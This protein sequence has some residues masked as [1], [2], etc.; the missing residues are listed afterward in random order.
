M[1]S[2]S[3]VDEP[4]VRALA[5]DRGAGEN[6]TEALWV[7]TQRE[8]LRL[9]AASLQRQASLAVRK[10]RH[11]AADGA[12]GLWAAGRERL[13]YFGEGEGLLIDLSRPLES[14][15]IVDLTV[16]PADQS[17][18]LAGRDEL[19][20]VLPD[21]RIANR[22]NLPHK[23]PPGHIAALGL[24]A[25]VR[26]PELA[27][28]AP[29]DGALLADASPA[30][31]LSHSDEGSGVD[32]ATLTIR[33]GGEPLAIVCQSTD[34]TN[35]HSDCSVF[36]VLDQGAN[37]LSA[38]IA[39]YAGN[40]SEPVE[41][42][43]TIDTIPPTITL[44][45]PLDG[46]WTNADEVIVA[47][48]LSENAS[49]RLNGE[50]VSLGAD[51]QF[52]HAV[53]LAEDGP[54][55][56][57]LAAEDA[58]G[59]RTER[60]V[61]VH[62]DTVAPGAVDVEGVAIEA[63][64]VE[65]TVRIHGAQGTVE[66]GTEVVI[67]NTRTGET[68]V[69][70][71]D[72]S[73]AFAASVVGRPS[74]N[75]E[76]TVRDRAG[77]ES[78][79]SEVTGVIVPPDPPE[80]APPLPQTG[81]APM[82][83]QV[84]FLYNGSSPI[85]RE[86]ASGTIEQR[87]VSVLKGSVY[88]REGEPVPGVKV[89]VLD[90]PEFGYTFT[91][92]DGGFDMAV[93]G[94]GSLTVVYESD[95][96]LPVQ[97]TVDTQWNGWYHADDVVLTRLDERV[98]QIDLTDDSE[99]FQ[100]ARGSVVE[101]NAGARQ[102]T[103]LFPAGTTATITLPDGSQQQLSQLDVRATE[104]TV[105][106]QGPDAMPGE[107]PAA[108][109]YTYAVELSVDQARAQG[110]K[111]DGKDVTFNQEVPFYVDNFLDFPTGEP[112]PTGYYDNDAGRWIPHDDGRIIEI[113]SIENGLAVLDVT[114]SGEPATA[115][116]LAEVGIAPEERAQ[117]AELYAP[118]DSLWRFTTDHLSTWDCNWPYGPPEDAEAPDVPEP[119]TPR[120]DEPDD[121]G[122]EN[123]CDGC[124][125]SPQRQSL[126]ESIPVAGTPFSLHYQSD[127]AP[128]A[129]DNTVVIPLTGDE[130]PDSL[131]RID[132]VISVAGRRFTEQFA[133]HAN[134]SHTFTWDGRD[135]F[136]RPILGRA[137]A[138]IRLSHVYGCQYY[139]S[140][141]D[142][143]F[144]QFGD[145]ANPI[146][147]RSRC[148]GFEF[149]RTYTITLE[150]PASPRAAAGNWSLSADHVLSRRS[151]LRGDGGR[152]QLANPI[153]DTALRHSMKDI[154]VGPDGSLYSAGTNT[155]YSDLLRIAPDGTS[156]TVAHDLSPSGIAVGYSGAVYVAESR[157]SRILR[158]EPNGAINT[159]AGTGARGFSGDGGP[160]TEAE[161]AYPEDVAIGTD[162]SIYIAD[163]GNH[164]I[165]RVAPDGT[166]STV[167]GNGSRGFSGDGGPATKAQLYSPQDVA[168][169]PDGSLF[170][171][172]R[173]NN[174]IRRVTRDG[175]IATMAG[176][177]GMA[178]GFSGDGGPAT[179]ALLDITTGVT[180]GHDGT[181]FVADYDN[182]RV[183]RVTPDG[184]ITTVAG[185]GGVEWNSGGFDGDG[186]P[187]IE[188]RLDRP[189]DV[190][191]GPDGSLYIGDSQNL[192]VRRVAPGGLS[193]TASGDVLV[194]SANENRVFIFSSASRHLST[195]HAATGEALYTFERDSD[196]RLIAVRDGDDNTTAIERNAA[197]NATAIIAPDGQ[198][199]EL[200]VDADSH[201][202]TLTDPA[203]ATWSMQYTENGLMTRIEKPGGAVNAFAYNALGRL[204]EDVDPNGGGW[205]LSRTELEDGY[206][207]DMT[208]GEGRVHRF[209]TERPN[210]FTRVYTN[211]A[212]GGTNTKRTHTA[213]DTVTERADGTVV[214]TEE[215]PG[216]RYGMG[217]PY[218]AERH[219]A[220]PSG[221]AFEQRTVREVSL[222]NPADPLA[223]ESLSAT[224]TIN[225]RS[226]STTFDAA[227]R[228]W[229]VNT[230]VGRT[231]TT[232][233]DGQSR[234]LTQA[235][236]GL[237]PVTTSYDDRGRPE[238]VQQGSGNEARMTTFGYHDSGAQAGYLATVTDALGRTVSFTRDAA[239]RITEQTGPDG[240][241]IGYQYDAR[242][243]LIALTPP[244]REAHVFEY[245]GLDQ[246]TDYTP[247]DLS[248]TDT[249][250]RYRYNLDR[251]L[252]RIE[253]PGGETV[254]FGYDAGG[255]LAQRSG[256]A[257][258][259]AYTYEAAT[260]QLAA[261]DAPGNVRLGFAWDGFLSTQTSWRGP[262][263]GTVSR[264][265]DNN[266]WLT[267]ETVGSKTIGFG[268]DADGLLTDAGSLTLDRGPEHGLV[269]GT[270][271]AVIT[272]ERGYN[273]FGE[274]DGRTVT[275][276][277]S[278][279]YAVDYTRDALG[280]IAEK[281]VT[282]AGETHTTAYDY[283]P[284][285]RLIR[286]TRDGTV[287]HVYEYDAN[288]NRTRTLGPSGER[289]ATYDAQDRL[290]ADG[291]ATYTHTPAGERRT[292]TTAAGTTTYD[293]DAAGNLRSVELPDGTTIE[294]LIDGMNR[295][296]GKKVNGTLQK[297]WLY[298][299]Q[300]NPVAQLNADGEITRRFVY[301]D[302]A[303][304]P[305]YMIAIDPA[306]GEE[307]EYR[308]VSD[309]L[310]S[311][312]LVVHA[313]TGAI[314]QRMDYSPFGQ[315]TR[316][317]NPG[318]QPFGFAGGL[319]D[320][321]TGLVRFGARD[322]DPAR[323]R[324]TAKDPIGFAG[325][326]TNLYGYAI[327]DPVNF[328]DP[329]GKFVFTATAAVVAAG[330][331]IG[332]SS[333]AI[334]T[335]VT[336][337]S[338]TDAAISGVVGATI[339][340]VTGGIGSTATT[341]GAIAVSSSIRG[342]IAG[343]LGNAT[344]QAIGIGMD[345]CKN[346]NDFNVGTT[347]GAGVGGALAGP[348][349]PLANM[350]TRTIGQSVATSVSAASTTTVVEAAAQGVGREV[351]R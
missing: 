250:T 75:Y 315:V 261:I 208:S 37:V 22:L 151:L 63:G 166:I 217:A 124:S 84:S 215:E 199:T 279:E 278:A 111:I 285:G 247:P 229:A 256:P 327:N 224:T 222:A 334:A 307:T 153:I 248:G 128:G 48:H 300:L 211:E 223:L 349:G 120:D 348:L 52:E 308:I 240:R 225:G 177:G 96:Y 40:I 45:P 271:Q 71:A 198:R 185:S 351:G 20:H 260:G 204:I 266:F 107:L 141:G 42:A 326:T 197:G 184:T 318:F 232:T 30:L 212:P 69:A 226:A 172:D 61:T 227:S 2:V 270:A 139:G 138:T 28:I 67:T 54:H 24:F 134:Q 243:N 27:W 51:W 148:L 46:S 49:L 36:S 281:T 76:I 237:A 47:G 39:D 267:G 320:R 186:G 262:V 147:T 149:P 44:E 205:Q 1:A 89:R 53:A 92:A 83:D 157:A 170:I 9:D 35:G 292:K 330:A 337:G 175:T 29:E 253:R 290:Q 66:P 297:G 231:V 110:V 341:A 105:G 5:Y 79:A 340:A 81:T 60:T 127:R 8:V 289:Q 131:K 187:A 21:G 188:A 161:L 100:V 4:K 130:L 210:D 291:D 3:G 238:S 220:L 129:A 328:S 82:V 121:S 112:V 106:D 25:D 132:L 18:W 183:R 78:E 68:F 70:Q 146:G 171:A 135:A 6:S 265:Y 294:Y 152:R 295:R 140:A 255:R 77:N 169:G 213:L 234:P 311:V 90:H 57:A 245:D 58:A 38:T 343:T 160:A 249:M 162:G 17:L 145:S 95:G 64:A 209:T 251:Q 283:D 313:E 282:L 73:G 93:N 332:G 258:T 173:R 189:R 113:L 228:R 143:G 257:G 276:D 116:Q 41:T 331:V 317:S 324:W 286:V 125:I 339:G 325:G 242:G 288:G 133:P 200:T 180:V 26:S 165:R 155:G 207:T 241:T 178:G 174:R 342:G 31:T 305:A 252:T 268:Y 179:L 272:G 176:S 23:Q 347:I 154:A 119:E 298:R 136:G 97:R 80:I 299:D 86:V 88:S 338:A 158:V 190:A 102:A 117:L 303:N 206:R 11:L 10:V 193:T 15:R 13:R 322:Y 98:T 239:G 168:V 144:G 263:V 321:D 108:S 74:D 99:A 19:V 273:A 316:N 275:V 150:S 195:R 310:G 235:V 159:V 319:Y 335:L 115:D 216:P 33:V 350:G 123:D 314:A 304:V 192:R 62:R 167:A 333:S 259:T 91:Q 194:A 233:V 219:I 323:G 72:E 274:L 309:H 12:G 246:R 306:T 55:A 65:G 277:G 264:E 103:L 296:I 218:M 293:Y 236:A 254:T 118:G 345:S 201:L 50:A 104:Y 244:G 87:R 101:D 221:L 56:L 280:R 109:A 114:G 137:E 269:T 59:N 312:R 181:M 34:G 203:G 284:A 85:Q 122:E 156:Y 301:A 230:P 329:N 7:A 14:G 182:H 16:N 287:T 32:P 346:L 202:T 302:Q 163:R 344:G 191:V 126:G 94:G 214:T 336:G 43:V 164:R 142:N 196:G